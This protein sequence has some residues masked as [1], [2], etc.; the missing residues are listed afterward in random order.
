ME[1]ASL[2]DDRKDRPPRKILEHLD[3]SGELLH[4]HEM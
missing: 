4:V 3:V 2:L 1:H